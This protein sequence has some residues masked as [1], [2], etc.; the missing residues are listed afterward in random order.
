MSPFRLACAIALLSAAGGCTPPGGG[1]SPTGGLASSVAVGTA[2][3]AILDLTTR[4]VSY[5]LVL[6]GGPADASL[7]TTRIAF[8]RVAVG[9]G[10]ALVGIFE[11]TQ[12]QWQALYGAPAPATWPWQDVPDAVCDS[13]SAHGANR[14]AYNLDHEMVAAVLAGFTLPGG[15][16]LALP[17]TAQWQAACGTASGWSWGDTASQAQLDANAVVRETVI[18]PT[19]ITAGGVDAGGAPAVGS[20]QPSLYGFYDLHGSV[21]E[22]IAGGTQVCGGSWRDAAWQSRAEAATG[23]GQGFHHQLDH[24]LVGARLVLVP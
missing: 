23:S 14:P 22:L 21:W 3:Y 1:G 2:P 12:A 17:T 6:P 7:R 8:R 10:E 4:S 19:R 13:A 18:T 11:L 9:S 16:R 24:A 5:H 15:G 20:R